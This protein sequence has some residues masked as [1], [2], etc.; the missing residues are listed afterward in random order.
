MNILKYLLEILTGFHLNITVSCHVDDSSVLLCMSRSE[1]Q[2]SL[3]DH[4]PP[5]LLRGRKIRLWWSVLLIE[6]W[7]NGFVFSLSWI[8][9]RRPDVTSHTSRP[10][11]RFGSERAISARDHQHQSNPVF[12]I[13][14]GRS[15]I[16]LSLTAFSFTS[17]SFSICW[18]YP[19]CLNVNFLLKTPPSHLWRVFGRYFSR[20]WWY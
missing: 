10:L 12:L 5:D 18:Y 8:G 3:A 6:G 7:C 11:I 2:H 4:L 20:T 13:R 1:K 17:H 9:D 16:S 15:L 14:R 19:V